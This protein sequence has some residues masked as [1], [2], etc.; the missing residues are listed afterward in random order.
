MTGIVVT[1]ASSG[2]GRAIALRLAEGRGLTPESES[3]KPNPGSPDQ[4]L[5]SE[6][7]TRMIVHYRSNRNGA[8]ETAARVRDLGVHCHTLQADLSNSDQVSRLVEESFAHLGRVS[9]WVNNAGVDVLT[10]SAKEWSFDQKLRRLLDVDVCGTISLS[11]LVGDRL[12]KQ[13][14]QYPA[15]PPPNMVFVGWD[16]APHGMEGDAGMMFGPVKAAVMAFANSLA[17]S[18]APRVR[19]N[20]VAPGWIQTAWGETAQ[21]YWDDRAKAQSLANRWGRPEDVA[22]A[23]AFLTSPSASFVS[24]QTINVN[25]GFNRRFDRE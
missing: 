22:E 12:L 16:Q 5:A 2:I 6:F 20:T 13:F 24:G 25:G 15:E 3:D 18:L 4:L 10:G 19:V 9:T 17:Q 1:G 8:E 23:V 11:R 21:G 14:E 7:A